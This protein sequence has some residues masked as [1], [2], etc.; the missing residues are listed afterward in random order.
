MLPMTF[1]R[2]PSLAKSH[3]PTTSAP[4]ATTTKPTSSETAVIRAASSPGMTI[5]ASTQIIPD[6]IAGYQAVRAGKAGNTLLVELE[7]GFGSAL[8]ELVGTTALAIVSG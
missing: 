8:Q 1:I 3:S 7:T 2:I 5:L 4:P 6:D